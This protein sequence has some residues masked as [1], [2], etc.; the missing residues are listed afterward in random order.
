MN[1]DSAPLGGYRTA[2]LET[3][4][5]CGNLAPVTPG[6]ERTKVCGVCN[7]WFTL[8]P[9]PRSRGSAPERQPEYKTDPRQ[10]R[11]PLF[12]STGGDDE[13]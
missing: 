10:L 13:R 7:G 11:L 1:R 12:G 3:C 8:D 6:G 5:W 9:K 4:P 2:D